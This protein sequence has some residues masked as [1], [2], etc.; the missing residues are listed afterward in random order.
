[1]MLILTS[2][3]LIGELVLEFELSAL[4]DTLKLHA[5]MRTINL[6]CCKLGFEKLSD[7]LE[8][9][10]IKFPAHRDKLVAIVLVEQH[11]EPLKH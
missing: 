5:F 11:V 8:G 6:V 10:C 9:L 7:W 1:M 2:T 3:N 4:L